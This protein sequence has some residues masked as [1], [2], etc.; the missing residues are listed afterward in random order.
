MGDVAISGGIPKKQVAR[1]QTEIPNFGNVVVAHYVSGLDIAMNHAAT[2]NVLQTPTGTGDDISDL[3]KVQRAI[4]VR[5]FR[6]TS[7]AKFNDKVN[8]VVCRVLE[9]L[10]DL[11]NIRVRGSFELLPLLN[12]IVASQCPIRRTFSRPL[13]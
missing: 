3:R 4:H 2:M 11:H 10:Q 1:Y 6:R 12:Q 9:N 8:Y 13:F 5:I 7:V